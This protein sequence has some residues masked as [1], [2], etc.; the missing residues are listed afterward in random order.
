MTW[1]DQLKDSIV[2]AEQL[3]RAQGLPAAEAGRYEAIVQRFPMRITPYYFSLANPYDPDDPI[4][5]MCI[6]SPEELWSAGHKD[7]SGER[8]NVAIPGV[9]HKYRQTALVL[10]TSEC[11]MYCRHCFRKR[12]VGLSGEE[13]APNPQSVSGYL[14]SHP[15]VTNVLVSG[16]DPLTL[17]NH[18]IGEYLEEFRHV[19]TLDFV[20]FGSRMPVVLPQR[21]YGDAELLGVFEAFAQEKRLILVTQF[22]HPREL[23]DSAILA[24]RRLQERGLQVRNQTVLLKGVNDDAKTLGRLLGGLCR[25]GVLPYYVFQCRPA[26]GVK[27]RFQVP[28]LEGSR[29]VDEA[30]QGLDGITKAFRF[31][32]S[33]PRGKIEILGPIDEETMVFK[34]HQS[35][36]EAD[37]NRL[38]VARVD[39]A[40]AWLDDSLRA[41]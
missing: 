4:S 15:E 3:S 41:M 24:I 20:R 21:I 16:G 19:D 12:M 5:R 31:V 23:T 39:T 33:H 10:S 40:S 35:R 28:F 22:N 29:I 36:S 38:F 37:A 7:T 2:T 14:R 8:D 34:F 25:E 18:V 13:L 6:P 11:A 32:M 17:P 30:R 1:E 27:E 9:Q 26:K